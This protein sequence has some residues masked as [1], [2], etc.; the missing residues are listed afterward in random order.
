MTDKT[1]LMPLNNLQAVDIFKP[2]GL[3]SILEKMKAE[4][5][6][7][8]PD[9]TTEKGR[10]EIASLAYKVSQS[11]TYL[12][13]I[14]KDL[15]AEQK[16]E[17]KKVDNERSNMRNELDKLR[18]EVRKPLNDWEDS[19]KKRIASIEGLITETIEAGVQSMNDYLTL[20]LEAMRDRYAE[21]E[22]IDPLKSE[23]YADRMEEIKLVALGKISTAIE[24]R[25][26]HDTEQ[27]E[28]E[29]FRTEKAARE[30]TEAAAKAV[31]DQ[32]ARDDAIRQ[33]AADKAIQDGK[34]REEK[35]IKDRD[36]AIA[37]TKTAND[38]AEK[39]TQKAAQD[40]IDAAAVETEA[41]KARERNTQHKGKINNAIVVELMKLDKTMT[42]ESAK[43]IVTSFAKGKVA[44]V[45]IN[46]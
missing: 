44:S 12:D 10:K 36:D 6:L 37:A 26:K 31:R 33:E 27:E 41:Q 2:N 21:I 46:Y 17:L 15:V 5:R 7:L 16:L 9:L 13:G 25:E 42:M 8:V 11:K 29:Q 20:G 14:G 4:V 22:G 45:T 18:D 30:A 32:E 3:E 23:E 38:I 1:E 39:A 34:D 43:K 35:L 28:L 24:M 19:E 40:V